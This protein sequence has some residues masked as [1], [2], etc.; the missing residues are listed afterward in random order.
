MHVEAIVS[1]ASKRPY[2]FYECL[3]IW[4]SPKD[5][6]CVYFTLV[7]SVLEYCCPVRY[8]VLPQY[9][10]DRLESIQRRAMR[11]LIP[12]QTYADALLIAKCPRLNSR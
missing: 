8:S 5:L 12:E 3:G 4:N 9:L 7:R 11:L 2:C 10:F 1:K 6:L